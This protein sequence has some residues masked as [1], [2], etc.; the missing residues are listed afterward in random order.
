VPK[1]EPLMIR[2]AAGLSHLAKAQK[3]VAGAA[4]QA[5]GWRELRKMQVLRLRGAMELR[6]PAQDDDEH[7]S[8]GIGLTGV[9]RAPAG[10]VG[11]S[12]F[13]FGLPR[14]APWF[15]RANCGFSWA[16]FVRSLRDALRGAIVCRDPWPEPPFRNAG[17]STARRDETAPLRSG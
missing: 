7:W 3:F 4:P 13:L 16:I 8:N 9:P 10:R 12:F 11:N 2:F 1:D 17:P 14:S 6:R 5:W 15:A